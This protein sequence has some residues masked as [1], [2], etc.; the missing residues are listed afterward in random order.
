MHE[1]AKRRQKKNSKFPSSERF[2][3]MKYCLNVTV[4][5]NILLK[6]SLP[7]TLRCVIPVVCVTNEREENVVKQQN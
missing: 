1:A 2:N 7:L 6:D 3:F 5:E 4:N